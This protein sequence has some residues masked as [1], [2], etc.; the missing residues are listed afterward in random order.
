MWPAAAC[1][2]LESLTEKAP[3][4]T[5]NLRPRKVREPVEMPVLWASQM[6]S[7]WQIWAD[8]AV[9]RDN[10]MLKIQ[11]VKGNTLISKER[12]NS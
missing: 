9:L 10:D 5:L 1:W 12:L 11:A 4:L 6:E 7:Q 3:V 8:V 2:D